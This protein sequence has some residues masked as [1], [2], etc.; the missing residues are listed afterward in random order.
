M[1]KFYL[2]TALAE[3]E[4][5]HLIVYD[6]NNNKGPCQWPE[7]DEQTPLSWLLETMALPTANPDVPAFNLLFMTVMSHDI[8]PPQALHYNFHPICPT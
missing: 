3:V 8:L 1:H 4:A 7:P 6:N 5:A 2:N